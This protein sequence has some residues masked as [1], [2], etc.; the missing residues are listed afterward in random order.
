MDYQLTAEMKQKAAA[1]KSAEAKPE[2]DKAAEPSKEPEAKPKAKSKSSKAKK[3]EE[4]AE[5]DV[6]DFEEDGYAEVVYG[7]EQDVWVY[8]GGDG[9]VL[10]RYTEHESSTANQRPNS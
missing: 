1:K 5:D 2:Q 4:K 9:S 3:V 8:S 10:L 6:F 7:D